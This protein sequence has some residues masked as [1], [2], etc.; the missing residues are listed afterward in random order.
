M[1]ARSEQKFSGPA[2]SLRRSPGP[3]R[4]YAV[5]KFRPFKLFG[6]SKNKILFQS[7]QIVARKKF[8][9]GSNKSLTY[10]DLMS[11]CPVSPCTRL[12]YQ[13][14]LVPFKGLYALFLKTISS[15]LCTLN[16]KR[17]ALFQTIQ[18]EN[19]CN[20]LLTGL[21][22]FG[23]RFLVYSDNH[24]RD[25][26]LDFA[27]YQ[28]KGYCRGSAFHLIDL[29]YCHPRISL[30]ILA[31]TFEKGA[32]LAAVHLHDT[33]QL[34]SRVGMEFIWSQR[35]ADWRAI[36]LPNDDGVYTYMLGFSE[37]ETTHT[38][39]HRIV[40]FQKRHLFDPML[41]LSLWDD[42]KWI[43]HLQWLAKEIRTSDAPTSFFTLECYRH[44]QNK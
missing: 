41:G 7:P 23:K 39:G 42:K 32:P 44:F 17:K 18:I 8:P 31:R 29:F 4:V 14:L 1:V 15:L 35:I 9:L 21:M 36:P 6:Y 33:G 16:L 2:P 20:S 3:S 43:P 13:A 11:V 19:R 27:A 22:V 37:N 30:P 25:L 38:A 24:G 12:C 40:V 34:P 26:P 5:P 10:N 28:K